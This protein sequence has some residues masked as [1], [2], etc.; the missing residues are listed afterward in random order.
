MGR[1]VEALVSVMVGTAVL[2]LISSCRDQNLV[3]P[4]RNR[5]PETFITGAPR[6]LGSA[7]V[8]VHFYWRAWDEDGRSWFSV[9]VHG[10][11]E[12]GLERY[13]PPVS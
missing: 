3:K 10:D 13:G 4:D 11:I 12:A 2:V 6:E 7:G 9:D 1:F 5:A 8:R